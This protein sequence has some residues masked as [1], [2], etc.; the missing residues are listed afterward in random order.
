[1]LQRSFSDP[2]ELD[3]PEKTDYTI[4]G[5]DGVPEALESEPPTA[6]PDKN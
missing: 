4:D 2:L 6:A 3:A 5:F 1:M